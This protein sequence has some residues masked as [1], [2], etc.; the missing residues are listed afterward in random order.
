MKSRGY[1]IGGFN[2]YMS[3]QVPG[4]SGL[5]S[6]AAFE[7]LIGY[8]ISEMFNNSAVSAVELAEMGQFSENVFFGKPAA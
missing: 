1:K 7:I 3:S 8:I 2:G 6:S 4:G 5:S